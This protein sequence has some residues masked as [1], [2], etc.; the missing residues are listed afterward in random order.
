MMP[1]SLVRVICTQ[2]TNSKANLFWNWYDEWMI[3]W[4]WWWKWAQKLSTEAVWAS[5]RRS[6]LMLTWRMGRLCCG[7]RGEGLER[8][9]EDLAG[10]RSIR[11]KHWKRRQEWKRRQG[12]ILASLLLSVFQ[13]YVLA[14]TFCPALSST[15][16]RGW[17]IKT[18]GSSQSN[19]GD[20]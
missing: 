11:S 17:W 2:S 20:R 14:S 9:Q 3:Q 6:H 10:W 4:T 19:G 18:L 12:E 16:E 8:E 13:C 7:R 15:P 5:Q 1:T